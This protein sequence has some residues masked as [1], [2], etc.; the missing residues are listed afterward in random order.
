M[1]VIYA[2]NLLRV[3]YLLLLPAS[4]IDLYTNLTHNL[5]LNL[6]VTL[7]LTLTL[8]LI[9]VHTNLTLTLTLNLT[10]TRLY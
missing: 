5:S 6:T 9:L 4:L 10:L 1:R 7:T 3:T 2:C 8:T